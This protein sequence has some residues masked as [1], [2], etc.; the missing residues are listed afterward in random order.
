MLSYKEE[1]SIKKMNEQIYGMW[2]LLN[3]ASFFEW[4]E[5]KK[6]RQDHHNL[7][8]EYQKY[9]QYIDDFSSLLWPLWWTLFWSVSVPEAEQAVNEIKKWNNARAEEILCKMISKMIPWYKIRF[10]KNLLRPFY[11][12]KNILLLAL[13]DHEEKRYHASIPVL[14]LCID[15]IISDVTPEQKWAFSEGSHLVIPNSIV[16]YQWGLPQIIRLFSSVR[17][18]TN[19]E[20]IEIPYRNWILHGHDINYYNEITAHKTLAL[21]FAVFDWVKDKQEYQKKTRQTPIEEKSWKDF[22][23]DFKKNHDEK[24]Y[25][26]NLLSSWEKRS[27]TELEIIVKERR[28]S[29][30]TPEK[31]IYDNFLALKLKKYWLVAQQLWSF[32]MNNMTI[33]QYAGMLRNIMRNIEFLDFQIITIEDEAPAVSQIE[34]VVS[35]T[36]ENVL[37]KKKIIQRL[38][39]END[40]GTPLVRGASWWTRKTVFRIDDLLWIEFDLAS[41]FLS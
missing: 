10:S 23:W 28:Y 35:Y 41:N 25:Q 6:V 27:W 36:I 7:K 40:E 1:E 30:N 5:W 12:R 29:Q 32:L 9:I 2:L 24:K 14:L 26:E 13:K 8:E 21:L 4:K 15:G 37:K 38:I 34:Y 22:F 31:L 39:Y 19:E 20:R 33:K 11:I 16:W 3:I 17:R 18:K